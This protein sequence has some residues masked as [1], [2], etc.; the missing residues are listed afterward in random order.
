[1]RCC[2]DMRVIIHLLI[3]CFCLS[4]T[5]CSFMVKSQHWSPQIEDTKWVS[6]D[7]CMHFRY[8]NVKSAKF[9]HKDVSFSLC[10]Y[11]KGGRA[12]AF[13]PPGLPI[14]PNPFLFSPAEKEERFNLLLTIDSK[15]HTTGIDLS[16]VRIKFSEQ[17][18]LLPFSVEALRIG[19]KREAIAINKVFAVKEIVKYNLVFDIPKDKVGEIV[20]DLGAVDIDEESVF[21]PPLVYKNDPNL[22][23]IPLVIGS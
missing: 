18:T 22:N 7:I 11:L 2:A 15:T 8:S 14:L 16:K 5:A 23:Y 21:L 3:A 13:G 6:S 9:E 19:G 12:V 17:I 4:F 10:P 20:I 1:M